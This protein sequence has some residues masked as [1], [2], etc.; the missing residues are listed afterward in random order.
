MK[1][2]IRWILIN[3]FLPFTPFLVKFFVYY[4][5]K[6][7]FTLE[8]IFQSSELIFVSIY[9]IIVN[10][11]INIDSDKGIFETL[12]K[13]FLIIILVSN[14][15]LLGMI[16]SNNLGRNI[17]Q[18]SIIVILV[19]LIIAPIYKFKYSKEML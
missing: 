14:F 11:N 6:T 5:G 18:Y 2:Y 7:N 3:L 16:Y 12:L 10:L 17:F 19:P 13:I 9:I 4:F 8:N 1:N 15:L